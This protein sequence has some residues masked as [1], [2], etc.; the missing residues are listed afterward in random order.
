MISALMVT[1]PNRIESAR[2]A[3]AD[4]AAQT[5]VER[6]LIVVHDGGESLASALSSTAAGLADADIRIISVEAGLTLGELRN[7]SVRAAQG[8]FICQ[9]D[10]DDRHHRQR[11]AEQ[12]SALNDRGAD[13]CF[14][15]QQMHLF[16]NTGEMFLTDWDLEPW[17]MNF[18]QGSML[19]RRSCLPAY[20]ALP[21]G[22]DTAVVHEILRRGHA[23][24]RLAD[25]AWAYV[26]V[27]HGANAWSG[28][29]HRAIAKAK[30]AGE[31]RLL[32]LRSTLE[33]RLAEYDPPLGEFR[34]MH[35]GGFPG[36]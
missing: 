11:L 23:I 16:G 22:E 12:W 19:A 35:A 21:R 32:Q 17:P 26:Y 10:D 9:W 5:H 1:Q 30:S 14:L 29:H 3:M 28:A 8:D 18:V 36:H 25:R 24:A 33:A 27:C 15:Q 2:I 34:L 13:F 20:P 4:F 31:V 7:R 6:E